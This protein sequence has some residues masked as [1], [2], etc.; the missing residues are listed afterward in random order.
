MRVGYLQFTPA[1]NNLDHTLADLE[2][3]L[4]DC[5]DADLL[6]LPEL[7]NSGY[8]FE[9]PEHALASA[10]P[11]ESGRFISFLQDKCREFDLNIVAGF[12]EKEGDLLFNS[13]ALVSSA[14]VIGHYR[15]MHLFMNEKD[16]FQPGNLGFPVFQLGNIKIGMLICFDWIFPEAWRIM[17]L[18]G[19][20][21]VCHPSNLVLPGL[22]QSAIPI[23]A[24]M[25]RLYIITANRIGTERNLTFTG[26][27]IIADPKGK[28]LA[29]GHLE[30]TSFDIVEIDPAKA[31]EKNVTARNHIITDRRPQY[32]S[33]LTE[34][35]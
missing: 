23:N 33:L 9:S 6:V 32:Y 17:A 27:S 29:E 1:L 15:K 28:V 26:R 19:A 12:N 34:N 3:L 18:Q 24:L 11:L 14:G 8:N 13:S 21:I 5:R 25:N 30:G 20:D 16:I 22:A 7:A 2:E 4:V 10:E 31:R 35:N